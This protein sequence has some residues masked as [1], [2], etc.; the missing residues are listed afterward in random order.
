MSKE[1]KILRLKIL[2]SELRRAELQK[3]EAEMEHL[4]RALALQ[5]QED[6]CKF[7]QQRRERLQADMEAG[8]VFEKE[9]RRPSMY[10]GTDVYFFW[11]FWQ[12]S[13]RITCLINQ[14]DRLISR[15]SFS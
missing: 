13:N 4:Q 1:E 8:V 9:R 14:N 10:L 2:Q 3:E 15:M 7:N 6:E 11:V 5:D 12:S